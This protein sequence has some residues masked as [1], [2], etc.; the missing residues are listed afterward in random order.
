MWK[1][2]MDQKLLWMAVLFLCLVPLW[3][4]VKAQSVQQSFGQTVYVPVYSHIYIG[5]RETPFYLAATISIRNTDPQNPIT[6]LAGEYYDSKGALLRR[7]VEKPLQLGA[8]EATRYVIRE[9]DSKGGSGA[10]FI[11]KWKAETAVSA[12]IIESVMIGTRY[13]QGISFLSRGQVIREEKK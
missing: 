11:V 2:K 8:M 7:Y 4:G 12:P 3:G 1:K 9:S 5:D 6:V 10:S 13:N